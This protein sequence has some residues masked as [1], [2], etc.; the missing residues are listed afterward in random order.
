MPIVNN[1]VSQLLKK[2]L[3]QMACL[4]NFFNSKLRKQNKRVERKKGMASIIS[5]FL[6]G[7][8]SSTDERTSKAKRFSGACGQRKRQEG[9]LLEEARRKLSFCFF[10]CGK[11]W[12]GCSRF[13][14]SRSNSVLSMNSYEV[15]RSNSECALEVSGFIFF[16]LSEY[17]L[18]SSS[19][20]SLYSAL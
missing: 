16:Y 1:F 19:P 18:G 7:I 15:I 8:E 4:M 10:V 12:R 11:M 13:L 20:Y 2:K 5:F 6:C 14:S 9:L 17:P 3:K